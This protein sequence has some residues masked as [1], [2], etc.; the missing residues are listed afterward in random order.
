MSTFSPSKILVF[1]AT[2]N[3]GVFITDALLDASPPFGQIT[4]FTSPATVEKK[5]S[6]LDGWRKK[7]AKI[8]SGDID[9]EE[10]V[11]T[12][13]KDADTVISALGRDVIEKQID[14]IKLA[15]ETDSVKWFFPSE[16]G[17]DIEYN[18]KSAHEKPHQ[19]KLKVRK[20]IRENVRR[21]QYTYLVTGPYAD[22][23][24][25]LAAAAPEAGGFDSAN[26]KAVLVEDGDG[27]IGLITM[28]DVGT[29]LVASLRH[30]EAS[31]NKALKVQSFV[32]TGKE[33]LAEFEKQTGVKWDVTYSSLQKLR[34]AEE[35]AWAEGVPF[36]TIFTLRRIWAEGSTLYEKTDNET[37]GLGPDDVE[38]LEVAVKRALDSKAKL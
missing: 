35:K 31:F 28:K 23:F 27:K 7:G 2:G 38:T 1:G 18:S 5:A 6:L 21:L 24:F 11:K 20:Y 37:I 8:V 30:P 22:F 12:A 13:Y 10:Q 33:I 17:T 14:L 34:E 3:I 16:Y 9:D 15:E 29:T 32:A 36:A 19:K 26:H 4:I 25:K